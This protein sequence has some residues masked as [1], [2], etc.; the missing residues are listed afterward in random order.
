[1]DLVE[2]IG[3]TVIS[4]ILLCGMVSC[5]KTGNYEWKKT[6]GALTLVENGDPIGVLDIPETKGIAHKEKIEALGPSTFK[7]TVTFKALVDLDSV[8]LEAGFIHNSGS[9]FW[10]IPSV[11]YNGNDW[12]RGKEPKGAKADGQWRTVS[13]RR[14]PI[15]GAMYSEGSRYAIA[16]WAEAPKSLKESFSCSLRPEDDKTDH[17]YLWPE[18]EMPVTYANRDHFEPGWRDHTPLHKGETVVFQIYI[19]LSPIQEEHKAMRSFLD[20]AWE[21]SPKPAVD[22]FPS[23]KLWELGIRYA[24]E[25]LWAEE[26][27]YKGFSIGLVRDQDGGWKQRPGWKYEIGWCGQNASYAISLLE[28][29]LKNGSKESLD[30]GIAT[31]DTWSRC[32]LPNGLF[33]TNYDH[34]LSGASNGSIDACNLGTAAVNFFEACDVAKRC[35][36]ERPEYER[37]AFAICDFVVSDQQENG[38]YAKGWLPNGES[39]YREGTIGCFLVPAMIEAYRRSGDK[40]YLD[41]GL[42]AYKHYLAELKENGFTTA[43]ALDTWC[44]DKESSISLLRSA[45]RFHRLTGSPEFIEDA[46][47]ISYYLS[48][49]LWHYD[50]IYPEDDDFSRYGYHTFGAT[51][52]SVQHNHLDPYALYWVP[53]WMELSEITGD[54]QWKE[55]ALAI[56]RNSNQLVSDGTLEI[57]GLLRPVGSQNEAYFECSWGFSSGDQG[58]RINNWLVAW[59]GAFRLET[60][61]RLEGKNLLD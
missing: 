59:P 46:V 11:N 33:V 24:K 20:K 34:I 37:L 52:V 54:S 3:M 8:R 4:V 17:H 2:K 61:R 18:E 15:P 60:I 7:A 44:I 36:V 9:G 29:Y 5:G 1:M 55:K 27:D 14:T 40:K 25:S 32:G 26:G 23:G 16:T 30:K 43:G 35:E 28:D 22:I 57:H 58:H 10:M 49:W 12:G 50:G 47:A 21:L 45:M 39:I 48:T 38:C 42:K 53:E 41:S 56:W 19:H 31:L 13:F 6:D 51:S